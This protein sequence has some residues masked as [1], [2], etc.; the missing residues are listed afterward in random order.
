VGPLT[1][2]ERLR[3]ASAAGRP[4]LL[5]AAMGTELARRGV[6]TSPPLWS[7]RGLERET[8]LVREIHL[9]NARAGADVLT[10]NTFRTHARNLCAAG[11][12]RHAR[13]GA[14]ELT[15]TAVALAREAA[16]A[17]GRS[18]I[19]VA[20]SL[21]PLEDCY[22]PALVPEDDSLAREH[23]A[24]ATALAEAGC[25][26]I[27]VETMNAAREALAA[28]RAAAATGLSVAVS[29]VT[30]GA[31]LLLSGDSLAETAKALLALPAPPDLLAVNCVPARSIGADLARL[32]A[33]APG[34]PLGVY[35]NTGRAL[36][37]ARGIFT[38]PTP[39]EDYARLAASWLAGGGVA[40]LGS[41][42]GTTSAHTLALRTLIDGTGQG[43]QRGGGPVVGGAN[44]AIPTT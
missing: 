12:P 26:L 5:D 21:A 11:G 43:G 31:G 14:R 8:H 33:A 25:D 29:M 10:A 24:Q 15:R 34:V 22:T 17:S 7:A 13:P 32:R 35:A 2:R 18:G 37:E 38:E 19:L 23:A 42:C 30:D 44:P 41:C 27:L 4:L 40:L 39:P 1:F 3:E 20:G 6:D 28:A 16:A 9:E 36:D